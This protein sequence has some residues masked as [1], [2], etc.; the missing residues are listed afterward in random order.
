MGCQMKLTMPRTAHAAAVDAPWPT[1]LALVLVVALAMAAGAAAAMLPAGALIAGAFG[2]GVVLAV[3]MHPPLG[4]YLILGATPLVAGIDRDTVLP[5]LRPSEAVALLAGTGVLAHA[6]LSVAA[7]RP[8]R[9]RLGRI[10]AALAAL[11]LA[12]TVLPLVWMLVRDVDIARDDMLYALQLVK[13]YGI[14]LVVRAAVGSERHVRTALWISMGAAVGVALIAVLQSLQLFGVAGVL[15]QHFAPFDETS[16]VDNA[17]GTSTLASSGAVA[18]VMVFNLAI[19]AGFLMLGHRSRALLGSLAAIFVLG[20]VASGQFAGFIA[21]IV[22]VLAI[23]FALG[24]V[25][26]VALAFVPVAAL[27]AIALRPVIEQ[28]LS[29]FENV[30]G[31]PPS[32]VARIDN[33]ERHFWPELFSDFNWVLGVRPSARVPAPEP[34]RDWVFIESGHTWLL[35][36][37]GVPFALAFFAFAWIGLRTVAPIA[38]ESRDAVAVAALASFTALVVLVVLMIPDP[39]LTL[40]GSAE[41][42]FSLLA[43]AVAGVAGRARTSDRGP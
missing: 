36:A 14:F 33:L 28:R 4:A 25:G 35:W 5:A 19:A 6:A 23:G 16:V 3:A 29:G 32:W 20:A 12:G 17:R 10:D 39:H 27:A 30:G 21:L 31:L 42:S 37:G 40:R 26:R 9:I 22:G 7:G 41:L 38:R 2:L 15:A 11:V 13:Y 43:L 24:R 34:W 18:D 8:L 1:A